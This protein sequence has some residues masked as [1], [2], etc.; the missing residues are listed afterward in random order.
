MTEFVE[1]IDQQS[2]V[3]KKEADSPNE[4][5]DEVLENKFQLVR[6]RPSSLERISH[7]LQEAGYKAK[8]SG[9]ENFRFILSGADGWNFKITFHDDAP[10][11]S[12]VRHLSFQFSSGW[13]IQVDELTKISEAANAFNR[14]YRYAKAFVGGDEGYVYTEVEMSHFCF[15]GVSDEA[16]ISYLELFFYLRRTYVDLCKAMRREHPAEAE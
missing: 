10:A 14:Q 8:I 9:D 5:S 7:I 4:I 15:D 6:L 12:D 1:E 13:S 11:G 16:F 2:M 3:E